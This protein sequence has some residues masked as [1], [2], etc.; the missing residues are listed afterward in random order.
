MET[1]Q[2]FALPLQA[3]LQAVNVWLEFGV[4]VRTTDVLVGKLAAHVDPQL[5][6]AGFDWTFPFPVTVK[7][8]A[9]LFVGTD[10]KF[11]LTERAWLI[12]TEQEFEAPEHA[13]LQP[14]NT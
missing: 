3:P 8:S 10:T 1:V 11:A 14:E 13:P 4:A 5:M 7:F 9:T 12:V 2:V 6:P